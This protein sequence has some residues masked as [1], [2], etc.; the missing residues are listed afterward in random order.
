MKNKFK[1]N[2]TVISPKNNTE[3]KCKP[4]EEIDKYLTSGYFSI[5]LKDIGLNPS[6]YSYPVIP[7]LQDLYTTIDKRFYKN[8]ILTY[9]L[10]QVQTDV[11]L[12]DERITNDKYI[13][14][15]KSFENFVFTPFITSEP[16]SMQS[17]SKND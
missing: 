7:T 3:N 9:G 14:F 12:F 8:Y 4:Q 2:N 16:S 17:V 15:K 13:Q 1:S 6:N 10:T 5:L 11:G